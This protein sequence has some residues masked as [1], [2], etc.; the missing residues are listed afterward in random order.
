MVSGPIRPP[1]QRG[2]VVR[3]RRPAHAERVGRAASSA[4]WLARDGWCGL[5]QWTPARSGL[6]RS[7]PAPR[8]PRVALRSVAASRL[9]R[10]PRSASA[11][12]P[13]PT[14]L[15][16]AP[17]ARVSHRLRLSPR[18]TRPQG[19]AQMPQP[20]VPRCGGGLAESPPTTGGRPAQPR[21][22]LEPWSAALHIAAPIP[23]AC[24]REPAAVS[25]A[26]DAAAFVAF[27]ISSIPL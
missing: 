12:K 20:T 4:E 23:A 22:P 27:V 7:P 3:R 5:R 15:R 17:P 25:V 1:P 24:R 2:T 6:P 10:G 18:P 11:L 26:S 14:S 19:L 16:L 9:R 21:P 13:G 8:M